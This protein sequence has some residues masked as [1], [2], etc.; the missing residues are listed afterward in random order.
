[1]LSVLTKQRKR[2]LERIGEG[3][4]FAVDV[5]RSPRKSAVIYVRNGRAEV[6]V[7]TQAPNYWI[8][9]FVSER[10]QWIEQRISE[11]RQR[12]H[13]QYSLRD[14]ATITYQGQ[15]TIVRHVDSPT[16]Q[17][18]EGYL[19]LPRDDLFTDSRAVFHTWLKQQAIE[20]IEPLAYQHAQAVGATDKLSELRFKKTKSRWGHCTQGGVV[21]FNWLIM[22]A[23]PVAI[24][25]LVA[26]EICHLVHMN[27]SKQFYHLV[28]SICVDRQQ[29]HAW[30]RNNEHKVLAL[31]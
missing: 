10:Q 14:G 16:L 28:D 18:K 13:E 5:Q 19:E 12:K 3:L 23:P 2:S 4:P 31:H 21:Q 26:H 20:Y 11:E 7:P 9:Q 6:R 8:H 17:F 1:M 24:D 27:H 15:A 25:Y 29:A 22:L 30:L